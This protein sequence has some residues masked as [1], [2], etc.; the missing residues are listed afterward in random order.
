MVEKN[1]VE[2]SKKIQSKILKIQS[3]LD[4]KRAASTNCWRNSRFVGIQ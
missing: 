2:N 1:P 4:L 3:T